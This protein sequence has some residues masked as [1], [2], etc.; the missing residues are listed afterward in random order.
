MCRVMQV[1][2]SG[3]YEWLI[4]SSCN[5]AKENKELSLLIR[6]IFE[7]GRGNYGSR[8]IKKSWRE[9]ADL[10]AEGVLLD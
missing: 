3:Y 5:R 10:L 1:S 8:T 2:R 9:K 6:V 4:S 7:E